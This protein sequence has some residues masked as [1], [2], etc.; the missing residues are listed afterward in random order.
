LDHM[1]RVSG[2]VSPGRSQTCSWSVAR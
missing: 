1:P 2:G